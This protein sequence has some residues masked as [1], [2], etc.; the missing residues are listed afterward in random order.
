MPPNPQRTAEWSQ[1]ATALLHTKLPP[2][3][4]RPCVTTLEA[5]FWAGGIRRSSSRGGY[6]LEGAFIQ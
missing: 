4:L 6:K 5:I 1:P 3:Q 2:M